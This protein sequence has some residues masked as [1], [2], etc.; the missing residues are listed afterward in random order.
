MK[1]MIDITVDGKI[2]QVNPFGVV[3]ASSTPD[4][5]LPGWNVVN[6]ATC[7]EKR[8]VFAKLREMGYVMD[9][10]T[11]RLKRLEL[12]TVAKGGQS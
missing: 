5:H 4:P 7:D 9:Y 11:D 10:K 12:L 2:F 6:S 1:A 8:A 3:F